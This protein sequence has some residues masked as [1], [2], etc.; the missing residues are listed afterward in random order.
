MDTREVFY[1]ENSDFC[2]TTDPGE[3]N[4]A[5]G[6]ALCTWSL[7]ANNF[8]SHQPLICS[9]GYTKSGLVHHL[10]WVPAVSRTNQSSAQFISHHGFNTSCFIILLFEFQKKTTVIFQISKT[11]L[12]PGES[13]GAGLLL[14]LDRLPENRICFHHRGS[15]VQIHLIPTI[16]ILNRNKVASGVSQHMRVKRLSSPRRITSYRGG[17]SSWTKVT[18]IVLV[19]F[20]WITSETCLIPHV[21]L[22][23]KMFK[24]SHVFF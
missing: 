18:W 17:G 15:Y 6:S 4:L 14:I 22:I 10:E 1:K 8:Q 13:G 3:Q 24:N 20:R 21:S 16:Y 11:K 5:R 23:V 9:Q 12:K 7:T 19:W 2:L